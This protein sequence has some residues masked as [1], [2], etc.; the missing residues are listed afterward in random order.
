MS[1]G[2]CLE[3]LSTNLEERVLLLDVYI[4]VDRVRLHIL[5]TLYFKK[6]EYSFWMFIN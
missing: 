2:P 5:Y 3:C 6:R 1:T 4:Y